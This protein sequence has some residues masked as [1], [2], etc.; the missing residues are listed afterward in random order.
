MTTQAANKS[1]ILLIQVANSVFDIA[2]RI[3]ETHPDYRE[4]KELVLS[5]ENVICILHKEVA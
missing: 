1:K 4:L 3:G 2:E 5:I